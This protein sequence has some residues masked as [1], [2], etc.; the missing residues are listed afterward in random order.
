MPSWSVRLTSGPSTT[1]PSRHAPSTA[2]HLD[3]RGAGARPLGDLHRAHHHPS[4]DPT[5]LSIDPTTTTTTPSGSRRLGSSHGRSISN[6]FPAIFRHS[7]KLD[8]NVLASK[9]MAGFDST[10][11]DDDEDEEISSG[12]TGSDGG[13]RRQRRPPQEAID[14]IM[15]SGQCMTCGSRMRWA[16]DV[17]SACCTVCQAVNDLVSREGQHNQDGGRD[18]HTVAGSVRSPPPGNGWGKKKKG[19]LPYPFRH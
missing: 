9:N 3:E 16:P 1:M 2:D 12:R 5:I 17:L 10:D 15:S 8:K 14:Q 4:F 13:P 7:K 19:P 11:E 18:R 6:P